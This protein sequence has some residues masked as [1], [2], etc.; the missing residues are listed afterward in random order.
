MRHLQ[1]LAALLLCAALSVVHRPEAVAADAPAD[2]QIV[3][4]VLDVGTSGENLLKNDG[5]RPWHVGFQREGELFVCDNL[6]NAEVQR[7][8]SQTVVLD[9]KQP[10]AAQ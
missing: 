5:W 1:T 7:G 6:D 10:E 8:A 3:K 2:G 4:A 9:Q